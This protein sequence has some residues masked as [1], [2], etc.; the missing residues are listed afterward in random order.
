[1]VSDIK[2]RGPLLYVCITVYSKIRS[3]K[4]VFKRKSKVNNFEKWKNEKANSKTD[5]R[6]CNFYCA[7][8]K[9]TLRPVEPPC[10]VRMPP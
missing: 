6:S 9:T 5:Y 3:A 7:S 10:G 1:M 2:E 8:V 4:K